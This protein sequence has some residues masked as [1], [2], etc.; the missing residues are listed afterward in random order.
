MDE[1]SISRGALER[2][3]LTVP[4]YVNQRP[5][6]PTAFSPE[7]VDLVWN[8]SDT[9]SLGPTVSGSVGEGES[10]DGAQIK[11]ED[12]TTPGAKTKGSAKRI[13][14]RLRLSETAPP[15]GYIKKEPSV[16]PASTP[17]GT[18]ASGT[19]ITKPNADKLRQILFDI[20]ENKARKVSAHRAGAP[21]LLTLPDLNTEKRKAKKRESAQQLAAREAKG[22]VAKFAKKKRDGP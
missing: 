6:V 16:T 19:P 21:E 10:E 9:V 22:I 8:V 1:V 18:S 17:T 12:K 5:L 7:A 2:R 4:S 11:T 14:K 15:I 13:R 20:D 3:L